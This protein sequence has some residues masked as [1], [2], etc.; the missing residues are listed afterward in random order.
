MK[1]TAV[2]CFPLV[3]GVQAMLGQQTQSAL[4]TG[5]VPPAAAAP[6]ANAQPTDAT[7]VEEIIVRINNSIISLSDLKR[8]QDQLK[9]ESEK[10]DPSVPAENRPQEQDLLRD[11]IDSR[12]L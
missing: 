12:L 8:S 1:I 10:I 7:V 6:A 3:L 11:L 2:L 9:N 5:T 4:S